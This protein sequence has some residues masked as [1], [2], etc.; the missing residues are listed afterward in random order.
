[1]Q[2]ERLHRLL[3]LPNLVTVPEAA[4]LMNLHPA[5]AGRMIRAGQFPLSLI[6]VGGRRYVR[7]ADLLR[8]L[9]YEI[10]E[11]ARYYREPVSRPAA[12]PRRSVVPGED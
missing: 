10:P 6:R 3:K 12:A 9:G 5:K 11:A 2:K 8:H 4:P 1:M 7:R